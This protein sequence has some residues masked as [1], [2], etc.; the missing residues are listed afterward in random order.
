M[1]HT[2]IPL[3]RTRCPVPP[4]PLLAP[5][6]RRRGGGVGRRRQRNGRFIHGERHQHVRGSTAMSGHGSADHRGTLPGEK[7]QGVR[8]G[9]GV[10]CRVLAD[11]QVPVPAQQLEGGGRRGVVSGHDPANQG[12]R[13]PV[14]P[15]QRDGRRV[16]P[17]AAGAGGARQ[18]ARCIPDRMV[19]WWVEERGPALPPTS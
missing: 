11:R 5:V 13:V 15:A 2:S 1:V 19:S 3:T 12:R 8:S 17:P 4:G 16:G 10:I 9:V 18:L 14:Q 7:G 6:M